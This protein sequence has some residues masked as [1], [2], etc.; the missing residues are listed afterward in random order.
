MPVLQ[1]QTQ[2]VLL[3]NQSQA[4]IA[5]F[6]HHR[7]SHHK[8]RTLRRSERASRMGSCRTRLYQPNRS[9]FRPCLSILL[10]QIHPLKK[11]M[12]LKKILQYQS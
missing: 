9:N 12:N 1:R 2:L 11:P 7:P 10:Q 4:L 3:C 6:W 5:Q 8:F